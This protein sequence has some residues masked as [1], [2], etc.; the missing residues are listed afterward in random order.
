MGS[1][2][3][4]TTARWLKGGLRES[5][6]FFFF[7]SGTEWNGLEMGGSFGVTDLDRILDVQLRRSPL[8][9]RLIAT[10][11]YRLLSWPYHFLLLRTFGCS[12]QSG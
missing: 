8:F 11:F 3:A 4:N 2:L 7:G 9:F 1:L 12:T 6:V 10:D 5:L